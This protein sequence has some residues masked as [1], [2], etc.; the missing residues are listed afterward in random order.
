MNSF[1]IVVWLWWAFDQSMSELSFFILG[2]ILFEVT[3]Y[4]LI[5]KSINTLS[6]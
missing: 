2:S 6:G 4:D 1:T 3:Q 5:T